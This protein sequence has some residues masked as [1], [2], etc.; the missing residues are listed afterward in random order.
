[1]R[2]FDAIR[3]A[4]KRHEPAILA[5]CKKGRTVDPYFHQWQMTPIEEMAWNA[6]RGVGIPMYPQYPALR[7]F[8]DFA[9]PRKRIALE[10]DGKQW[11]DVERDRKRD[12]LLSEHGWTVY[13][14][15]GADCMRPVDWPAIEDD[16]EERGERYWSAYKRY[17]FETVDG[18]VDAI[19]EHHYGI[20]TRLHGGDASK[21]IARQW[22]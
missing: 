17:A 1:M 16:D 15:T 4:W 20:A 14:V 9:D 21:I 2:E 3:E 12:R 8:L 18:L 6:I 5:A 7:F 11:H 10:C 22:A 19:A 13:R